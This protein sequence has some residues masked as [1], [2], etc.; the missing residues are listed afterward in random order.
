MSKF[1][2]F[3]KK[4]KIEWILFAAI[5]IMT[6]VI[7]GQCSRISK[8]KKEKSVIENN[9]LA[10]N[11]TLKNYKKNGWT[12]ANMRALQLRA[13]E[14]ADSLKLE[15]GKEPATI[16]KYIA[17]LHDTVY[18]Q[19]RVVHD[20]MYIEEIWSDKGWLTAT[21]SIYWE[22][23]SRLLGVSIPYAVNCET[24]KV[25]SVGDAEIN[26]DQNIW[27]DSYLYKDKKGF[28]YIELKSDYPSIYFSNGTA[29]QVYSPKDEYKNRKQFG[30]GLGVQVGYGMTFPNGAVKMSPYI[31]VGIGL[32]WNPRFLQF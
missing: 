15:R 3:I 11:D 20:T 9:L 28:T 5:I 2:E 29:I 25:E 30:L 8:Y 27:I 18:A 14:L 6:A 32:Q 1:T 13:N 12:I 10:A 22:K 19:V 16:I 21:D 7:F 23:S 17:G 31:G 26:L 4:I 24:G